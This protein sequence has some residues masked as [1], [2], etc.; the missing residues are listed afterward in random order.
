MNDGE[1]HALHYATRQPVRVRWRDG[2]ISAVEQTQQAPKT[3][4]PLELLKD[5][6]KLEGVVKTLGL[7]QPDK[8][9]RVFSFTIERGFGR[10]NWPTLRATFSVVPGFEQ[11]SGVGDAAMIGSFGHVLQILNSDSMIKLDLTAV[12]D[13]RV[14]GAEIGRRIVS[15]L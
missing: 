13:A 12:P 14:R 1:I 2:R 10:A 9:G 5:V 15:R 8:E 3:D 6:N 7:T 4:N 11:V